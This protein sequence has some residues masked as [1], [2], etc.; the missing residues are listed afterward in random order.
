MFSGSECEGIDLVETIKIIYSVYLLCL[1]SFLPWQIVIKPEVESYYSSS[2][3]DWFFDHID[4]CY[5]FKCC[6]INASYKLSQSTFLPLSDQ[7]FISRRSKKYL[8]SRKLSMF[9]NFHSLLLYIINYF[10]S[11][12]KQYF[13]LNCRITYLT[14]ALGWS[15]EKRQRNPTILTRKFYEVAHMSRSLFR[16]IHGISLCDSF[17]SIRVQV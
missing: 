1:F 3:I 9:I 5:D 14:T 15:G 10:N 16:F 7:L 6:R 11:V 8:L 12:L 13:H 2:F 17:F 4:K